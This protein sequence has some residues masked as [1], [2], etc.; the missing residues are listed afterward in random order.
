MKTFKS[1][2]ERVAFF[3]DYTKK[4]NSKFK[5]EPITE[6]TEIS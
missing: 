6:V 3:D 1:Y 2:E 5:T 4:Q